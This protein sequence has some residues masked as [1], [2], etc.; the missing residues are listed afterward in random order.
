MSLNS[1]LERLL[2]EI[3]K[4]DLIFSEKEANST[5]RQQLF[6]RIHREA[7]NFINEKSN[8]QRLIS[9]ID[10]T[11]LSGDDTP[12]RVKSLVDR[13]LSPTESDAKVRCASVCIYPAR[14]R[15]AAQRVK[16]CDAD[17]Q[18]ASVAAG[19]PSGQYLLA[20]RLAEIRLAVAD[21]A[22]EID[23]VI[24]RSLVLRETG[25]DWA[26]LSE[27]IASMREACGAG[28][29]LKVI[30]ST[31]ELGNER[32]IYG[33]S[34]AAMMAGADF[35][36]TSTGK[37]SVNATLDAAFVMCLA[38]RRYSQLTAV[39]AALP[40]GANGGRLVGFKAAGGVR[41]AEQATHYALLTSELLGEQWT[42]QALFRIGASVPLLDD[43]CNR[44]QSVK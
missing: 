15:D 36:K 40:D 38:I 25:A 26:R 1:D 33:A 43:I 23:A 6:D 10:L 19:F 27:E 13:A 31:G 28:V 30:L 9:Y 18:V 7:Q 2:D 3:G 44:I 39:T 14:V 24:D 32:N 34:M 8:L 5:N 11:T 35:I 22:T 21:G 20:T 16:E 42:E 37:E 29:Q 17:L 4:F 41:N 12:E